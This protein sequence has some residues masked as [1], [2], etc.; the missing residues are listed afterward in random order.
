MTVPR[1]DGIILAG[2]FAAIKPRF[3]DT[4]GP[5]PAQNP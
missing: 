1:H 3:A 4:S 5:I 2:H